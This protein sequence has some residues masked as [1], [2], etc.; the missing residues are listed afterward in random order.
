MKRG[1]ALRPISPA[2][3]ERDFDEF[4]PHQVDPEALDGLDEELSSITARAVEIDS[5][6]AAISIPDFNLWN[7]LGRAGLKAVIGIEKKAV[8][9]IGRIDITGI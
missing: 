4:Y 5:L 2:A 7:Q 9:V 8:E 1:E 3:E 6:E